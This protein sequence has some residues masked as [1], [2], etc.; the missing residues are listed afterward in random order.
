MDILTHFLVGYDLSKALPFSLKY[1]S[2]ALIIGAVLPD[3]DHIPIFIKKN[4]YLKYHRTF[5][6]S[7]TIAP[8]ISIMFAFFIKYWDSE[9]PFWLYTALILIGILSHIGLDL[10]VPYGI[11]LFYPSSK[12]YYRDWVYVIDVVILLLLLMPFVG[13]YFFNKQ[14]IFSFS[15]FL[16]LCFVLFRGHIHHKVTAHLKKVYPKAKALGVVP[17]LINPFKWWI[18]IDEQHGYNCFYFD[19]LS[20]EQAN[21][22][23]FSKNLD[24]PLINLSSLAKGFLTW[25]RFPYMQIISQSDKKIAYLG[26]LRFYSPYHHILSVCFSLD[27][28][29]EI[30][31]ERFIL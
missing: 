30:E 14:Y 21:V 26:D 22:K 7:L 17:T 1:S 13:Q 2:E 10:V 28:Y 24:N 18:I 4:H 9:G 3:I 29:G 23:Y 6:H 31:K 5:T 16:I 15:L 8:L 20:K 19:L 27:K 25:A 11:K 12:W